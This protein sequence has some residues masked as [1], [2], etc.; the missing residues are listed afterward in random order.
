LD[1]TREFDSVEMKVNQMEHSVGSILSKIEHVLEQ[2]NLVEVAALLVIYRSW[3]IEEI[4]W[5]I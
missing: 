3:R 1:T 5:C 2:L 4:C